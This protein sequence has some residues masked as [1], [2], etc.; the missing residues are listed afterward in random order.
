MKSQLAILLVLLSGT[1]LCIIFKKLSPSKLI[2]IT[3]MFLSL[4]LYIFGLLRILAIGVYFVLGLSLLCYALALI[5]VAQLCRRDGYRAVLHRLAALYLQPS[6]LGFLALFLILSYCNSGRLLTQWDDFSH[7]GSVVKEMCFVDALGCDPTA[8]TVSFK[9]YPPLMALF[10][11]FIQKLNMLFSGERE[12]SPWR[13]FFS[14]QLFYYTMLLPFQE[15]ITFRKPVSCLAIFVLWLSPLIIFPDVWTGNLIDPVLGAVAGAALSAVICFDLEDRMGSLYI[16]LSIATL[17][18]LKDAG[19]LFAVFV[20][21]AYI[22]KNF[23]GRPSDDSLSFTNWI[24][25][26]SPILVLTLTK[27]SWELQ[28][29]LGQVPRSFSAKIN[30]NS[31]FQVLMGQETSYRATVISNFFHRLCTGSQLQVFGHAVLHILLLASLLA[32]FGVICLFYI[33]QRSK[34]KH[35]LQAMF[36]LSVA[37]CLVYLLGL[38]VMYM[39]KFSEYEALRL[40]SF[41]RYLGISENTLLYLI[42]LPVV[43]MQ[44]EK[45]SSVGLALILFAAILSAIPFR[46][47]SAFLT[48]QSVFESYQKQPADLEFCSH[49][50]AVCPENSRIYFISQ[51]SSGADYWA[52]RYSQIP[53]AVNSSFTWSIGEPFYEG[54]IWTKRITPK[55]WME[56]LIYEYDYVVLYRLNV[57]FYDTFESIFADPIAQ[58]GI[59]A[60]DHASELLCRIA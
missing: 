52:F 30:W 28:L 18:L 39:Y 10:Q 48:K 22:I 25:M 44:H 45:K 58:E 37:L 32:V 17:V 12:F 26:F 57:Y 59:Y 55:A 15:R 51:Q 27:L 19:L 9:S 46:T 43:W 20:S 3:C 5:Y 6:F 16:L 35:F 50:N 60:V 54:D 24:P 7:W 11:Y 33:K 47:V 31:L 49:V 41:D 56:E 13:L 2:P 53:R 40:A 29:T 21:L 34:L 36:F 14:Y 4:V 38:C 1:S 42:L 23:F 8:I